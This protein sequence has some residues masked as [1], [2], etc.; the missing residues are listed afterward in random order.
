MLAALRGFLFESETALTRTS[1]KTQKVMM[2]EE[3]CM[4]KELYHSIAYL[5]PSPELATDSTE[6]NIK[7][8]GKKGQSIISSPFRVFP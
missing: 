8:K 4:A 6:N 7:G 2:F 1:F 5:C 3:T